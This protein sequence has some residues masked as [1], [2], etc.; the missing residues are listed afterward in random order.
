MHLVCDIN[1]SAP[2]E[3]IPTGGFLQ[4]FLSTVSEQ[5]AKFYMLMHYLLSFI[6]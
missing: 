2:T 3:M 5:K 6:T 1:K 4:E